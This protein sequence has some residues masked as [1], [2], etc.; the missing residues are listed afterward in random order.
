MRKLPTIAPEI[1]PHAESQG[2]PAFQEAMRLAWRFELG[3]LSVSG[4]HKL[5]LL[6]RE[7]RTNRPRFDLFNQ[8]LFVVKETDMSK[9][10]ILSCSDAMLWYVKH[11][12][13]MVPLLRDLPDEQCW[14]VREPSGFS[15]IL[16]YRD[17]V[18]VPD[19][20]VLAH[21]EL[22]IEPNDLLLQGRQW[23]QASVDLWGQPAATR[24]VIRRLCTPK[25]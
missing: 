18:V 13:Q 16:R 1:D 2:S 25:P 21:A 14:L 24:S 10:L 6:I 7:V 8:P 23:L 15:N 5:S 3:Y 9:L 19:G 22:L 4:I 17:G 20:Y 11:V 12:G